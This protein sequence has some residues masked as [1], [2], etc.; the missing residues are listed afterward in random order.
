[1]LNAFGWAEWIEHVVKD[2][3]ASQPELISTI[4]EGL[5]QMQLS[6]AE[7]PLPSVGQLGQAR[8]LLVYHLLANPAT[9]QSVAKEALNRILIGEEGTE[10]DSTSQGAE[11]LAAAAAATKTLMPGVRL[12]AEL[13]LLGI[14]RKQAAV[15][16]QS[17]SSLRET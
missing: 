14:M 9:P 16:S 13:Q 2:V 11:D 3:Q 7:V 15:Q 17:Q 8:S 4:E 1:M 10:H 6:N 12:N 5:A